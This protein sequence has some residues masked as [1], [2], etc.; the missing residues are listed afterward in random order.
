MDYT[1]Q[2]R[3]SNPRQHAALFDPLPADPDG[4]GEV[5]RN[6]VVHYRG[7]GI[8]FPPDRLTEI[9]S[10][11]VDRMLDADRG[12]YAA[13][14]A[15]PRPQSQRIV[16]CCRDFTLLTVAALRHK[17]VPARSR[18]GFAD[19][20]DPL[21]HLDHVITEYWDGSRWIATDS[22]LGLPD[23][24]LSTGGLR[25]A[26]QVWAAYRRGEIDVDKFGVG[27]ELPDELRGAA[28]VRNYVIYELAHRRGDELLLWDVW[29]G[30]SLQLGDDLAVIDEIADLLQSADAGDRGAERKLADL[31]ASDPRLRPGDHITCATPDRAPS[32]VDLRRST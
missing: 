22:Q 3:F 15:E 25:P 14:L 26:A 2:T 11:W 17:G 21:F 31:Y 18:I 6:L 9:D 29:G 4:I 12:R 20:F 13:P 8:D 19:Y 10:R 30:V 7:S 28:F 23:V 16:G 32:R 27:P 5:V 24:R 1:R